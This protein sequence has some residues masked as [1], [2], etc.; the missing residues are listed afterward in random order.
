M[1]Q[2][3]ELH[4]IWQG[5]EFSVQEVKAGLYLCGSKALRAA[6]TQAWVFL[7]WLGGCVQVRCF[8]QKNVTPAKVRSKIVIQHWSSK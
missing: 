2:P 6:K 4:A 1:L 5:K 8:Q 7:Q 3:Q